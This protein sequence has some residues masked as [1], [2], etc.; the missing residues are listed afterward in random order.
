M[1]DLERDRLVRSERA[2]IQRDIANARRCVEDLERRAR[3]LGE[4]EV[5]TGGTEISQTL[6]YPTLVD[7]KSNTLAMSKE[8]TLPIGWPEPDTRHLKSWIVKLPPQKNYY[9]GYVPLPEQI[10]PSPNGH[11]KL[12]PRLFHRLLGRTAEHSVLPPP[13]ED[14]ETPF[15]W[16]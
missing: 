7:S 13:A 9:S 10:L 15:G 3:I 1:R 4:F 6:E 5:A 11:K 12:R 16:S 8:A 14:G 2:S